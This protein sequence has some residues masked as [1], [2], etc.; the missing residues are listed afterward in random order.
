MNTRDRGGD[1]NFDD[2]ARGVHA[3]AIASVSPRTLAQ[4]QLRRRAATAAGPRF[5]GYAWP[6]ATACAVA[7]LAIG[8][9]LR[10]PEVLPAHVAT[11]PAPLAAAPDDGGAT[12]ALD[13]NPELFEWLASSDAATLAME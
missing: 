8:W 2:I 5:R 4:L 10:R 6:L 3:R 11:S 1:G 13:E 9:Q 12:L 7:A